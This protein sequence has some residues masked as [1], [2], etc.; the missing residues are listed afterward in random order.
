MSNCKQCGAE[1]LCDTWTDKKY[2][3]K[4]KLEP[5]RL[6]FWLQYHRNILRASKDVCDNPPRFDALW[7]S[8]FG[9]PKKFKNHETRERKV[10]TK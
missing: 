10:V 1:N 8:V 6:L 2:I 5:N 4:A 3:E 9:S 7:K